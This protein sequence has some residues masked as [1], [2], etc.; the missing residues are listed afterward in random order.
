MVLDRAALPVVIGPHRRH[1]LRLL[2]EIANSLGLES[3]L[4]EGGTAP[5]C[6]KVQ[7]GLDVYLVFEIDHNPGRHITVLE[8]IENSVDR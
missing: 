6:G 1:R 7:T 5:Q 3:R 4:Y 8:P 2:N